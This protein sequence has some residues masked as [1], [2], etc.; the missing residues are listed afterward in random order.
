VAIA[1]ALLSLDDPEKKIVLLDECTS[2]L[3]E[4]TEAAI[5]GNIWPLLAGKTVVVVTHRLS[6]IEELVDE[7]VVMSQGSVAFRGN[8][9]EIADV[10]AEMYA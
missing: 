9:R 3:D 1:Q 7:V 5:Y 8:K 10:P 6:A 4:Q 2:N